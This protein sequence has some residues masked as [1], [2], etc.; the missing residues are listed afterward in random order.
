VLQIVNQLNTVTGV[1]SLASVTAGGQAGLTGLGEPRLSG[2]G[3]SS[4]IVR[5]G[6]RLVNTLIPRLQ[7]TAAE[8]TAVATNGAGASVVVFSG[9]GLGDD[10]GV[11]ARRYDERGLPQ[12]DARLVNTTIRGNQDSPAVAMA[13]DGSSFIVWQGRGPGDRHGIFGQRLGAVGTP[14]G[15]ETRINTTVGGSQ[16][17]A[18]VALAADGRGVVV[19][20]GVGSGDLDGVFLQR[21]AVDGSPVGAEMR[22]NTTVTDQQ[23]YPSVAMT[24]AGA[25]V[26]T[27]S[28]RH[29]DGSD[30]G[31]YGQ[32]FN[33][34]GVP[35]GDEFAV[36]S[37][38]LASQ[39]DSSVAINGAGE[40]VVVWSGYAL[41]ATGWN[42]Y[43]RC[44]N[45]D[46]QPY[47]REMMMHSRAGGQQKAPSVAM[48]A[49]G[50]FLVTWTDSEPNGAGREVLARLYRPTREA[51]T[52]AFQVNSIIVGANSGHQQYS[53]V[54]VGSGP[55]AWIAW[56]GRG[57]S[58]DQGVFADVWETGRVN[59]PPVLNTIPAQ[60]VDEETQLTFTAV[61]SD[62]DL[63]PNTLQYSLDTGFPA[64]A[65]IDP[66]SG[67][68]TWTP[69]EAQ[70]P[71]QYAVVVRV[72]DNG[73]PALS[74]T[75]TVSI[76]VREVN[77]PPALSAIPAQAVDEES[78][79]TFTAVASDP[80]LP[81]NTLQ[82]SL[83]AGAPVGGAIDPAS[84]VFS[85][86]PT[87]AQGP[88]QYSVVVR[89]TD[90]GQP[91]L[92]DTETVAITVRE[93]NQPPVLN[94]IP[95]QA[96]DEQTQLTFTAV[97]SDPDLPGNTL[98]F[99][100]DAGAPASAAIDPA[101]GVFTW[102]PTE[103]QGPGQYSVVVRVTDNGQLALGDTETVSITVREVNRPPVLNAI[104]AQ[105]VDEE[106]Q[107]TFT[108]VAS[109]P[110]L[111]ANTLQFS[112]DAGAPASA[113]IDP[114]SGV[115]S[116]RP[117]EAQGPGQY[118]VVVRVTD[119][120]QPALSD[121]ETVSITVREVNRPPVLNT[122]PPQGVDEQTQLTFTAVASDADLP[123]NTLQFSLDAGAPASAA[124]DSASGVFT[125]TPTEAQGP[126]QYSVVVR[127]T[128]NG[129]PALSDTET[130]SITVREVNQL[131]TLQPISDQTTE[132]G[133]QVTLV[134]SA[135]DPDLP[136]NGL[137]FRLGTGAPER[138]L[139]DPVSGRFTWTPT[140]A[141]AGQTYAVTVA[142]DDDGTPPLS[143]STTFS[144]QVLATCA[145]ANDLNGWTTDIAPGSAQR[146]GTVTAHAC[147]A[148]MTEGDSL[149]VVLEKS[150][151]IPT[152]PS[153][154]RVAFDNLSFDT[155]DPDSMN[156]AFEMALVDQDGNSL[157]RTFAGGRD[158]FLNISEGWPA[159]YR[160]GI[161]VDGNTVTVGLNG[162]PAGLPAKI[163][164]R[165]VNNDSDYATTVRITDFAIVPSNLSAASPGGTLAG[166]A[167]PDVESVS[168]VQSAALGVVASAAPPATLF[169]PQGVTSSG[170]ETKPAAN[171]FLSDGADASPE[172]IAD[173][174]PLANQTGAPDSRGTDFWLAFPENASDFGDLTLRLFVTGEM[175]TTGTVTIPG[176]GFSSSFSVTAG[177]A[178][179]VEVPVTAE[180]RGS[181]TVENKGI[182]VTAEHEVTV[183]GLSRSP[184]E[185]DAY[186]G[187]PTDVLGTEYIALGYQNVSTVQGTQ[188]AVVGTVDGTTVTIT[189]TVSGNLPQS[190]VNVEFRDPAGSV[191]FAIN[192]GIDQGPRYL[193]KSGTYMLTVQGSDVSRSGTYVFRLLDLQ[194][195]ATPLAL[196]S[197]VTDTLPTGGEAAVY[198]FRGTFGQRLYYDAR[199]ADFDAVDLRLI[200]PSGNAVFFGNSDSDF[201]PVGLTED[202]VY[203]LLVQ[204]DTLCRT[205]YRFRLSDLSSA[206]ALSLNTEMTGTLP[207][208]R[209]VAAYQFSGTAGQRLYYDGLDA[210]FDGVD[211]RLIGPRE[212]E[213]F[214]GNSDSDFGP[215]QLTEDGTY[216]LLVEG[217]T[218]AGA[219]YRFR[220][221]D[222]S[223][224][225]ALALDTVKSGAL[226]TGREAAMY[227][228]RGTFGQRLYYD[229]LDADF[230]AVD[231][232]LIGPSGNETFRGNS[233][234]DAGLPRLLEDGTYYLLVQGDTSAVTDY[235]FR[236]SDLSSAP[237]LALNTEESGA[238]PTGREAAVYQ[239]R[240]TAGQQVYYDALDA[241]FDAVDVRLIGPRDN[242]VFSQN[243]DFDFGPFQ[244]TEDGTYYLL[245]PGNTSGVV[246]YRFRLSNLSAAPAL[247]LNTLATGALPTGREAAVYQFTGTFGQRLY[248]D[249]LDADFDAV[250]VRLIAPRDNPVFSQNSDS[251][252]GPFQLTEDG[253]YYLLVPGNTSGVVDYRFQLSDVSSA[254]AL[255]L[256]TVVTGALPTGREA[257]VY[258]FSGTAGQRL[259]YDSLDAECDAV[260]IRL[261]GPRGDVSDPWKSDS[262]AGPRTLTEDGMYYLLVPGNTSGVVD[263]RFQLSDLSSAPVLA[264]NTEES[265][266][267]PTGRE[268]AVYQFRG[269]A[270]QRLYYDAL[271]ADFD[272]VDVRLIG[273]RD[274]RV[275]SQNS[276]SD[277]GPFQL[278]EDGTY[279]LVVPG[280]TS[281][282]VDY[283]FRL[284]DVSSAPALPLNTVEN[285]TLTSGLQAKAYR[286][287]GAAFQRLSFTSLA[288][289]PASSGNWTLYGSDNQ[290]V[291]WST[292]GS[293]FDATLRTPG[294]YVLVLGG[295]SQGTPID[296]SFQVADT[297]DPS[298]PLSGFGTEQ[299][300]AIGPGEQ[301]RYT[302]SA[303]AGRLV[304]LDST[305]TDSDWL[306][307]RVQDPSNE[308]I[309]R[310]TGALDHGPLYLPKS[311]PYTLT[312]QGSDPSRS[313]TYVFRL[314]DFQTDASPL[315]FGS[316]V[317][318]ALPTG[319]EVAVYQ[320]SGTAG[321]RPY[322]DALDADFD[323]V[324]VRLIGPRGDAWDP[325]N[326]DSDAG[327]P[328]LLED[329]TYYLLVQGD[330][331]AVADYSFCVSDLSSAPALALSTE[332][333]GALPTGR[334]AAMYQFRGTFGQRLY[335]DALDAD[336]DAV[337]VR[338]I[339]P[340][341]NPVFSQNS[342][343]DAGP[344]R[345]T[346]DGTYCLLVQG[347][348]SAGADYRFRL[349]DLSSAPALALNTEESGALPTGREA[350]VYQFR[351]TAGQQLYYDGLDAD[352]DAVDVRLI[353][354]RGNETFRG[355]SDSDAG[356]PRLL[357]DGTYYLLVQ[358]DT[359][360][361]ADYS[362]R[363]N[364]LSS[365]PA[366][367]LNTEES[368]A[369]PTGRE[370][371]VYQ[372]RGTFGQRL[373]YDALDADF[374]AV[375]VRLIDPSGNETFRGN[376]DSDA[377]LPRLLE[378]GTHYLLV[379]GDNSAGADYRFRLSDLSSAP[380]L[381]LNTVVTGT[382]TS[383]LQANAYRFESTVF[384][385]LSFT[386][387][388]ISPTSAGNWTLYGSN[389]Q[390]VDGRTLGSS[391]DA[392][393]D[394]PGTYVLVLAGAS[395]GTPID[396][397]FR[398]TNT[399]DPSIPPS[400]FGTEQ[401]A[402]IRP[403][404]RATYTFSAPAGRL[405]FL[406]T[407]GSRFW[408]GPFQ[409]RLDQGETF[410]LRNTGP[411]PSDLSGSL[412]VA[413][414][415]IAVFGG[416]ECA[417]IP[418]QPLRGS[419]D[420]I[421]E[422][423]PP[424]VTWG[425]QFVTMPL[426]T[427]HGGDT[428]RFLGSQDATRVSV[429][430]V[431]VATLN[432]G[433]WYEQLI[434]G[435][436]LI[437]SDNPI[438]VAQY[439]NGNEFDGVT[440]SDP[441]MMLIPPYEQ[442]LTDYT[443]TVPAVGLS[444][445]YINL[446]ASHA[447]V[448]TI[449]LDGEVVPWDSFAS[450]ATSGFAG[451]QI[452]VHPGRHRLTGALPF[453]VFVYG[454]ADRESYGYPGGLSLARIG[455]TEA[456]TL[457]PDS[458][459][460]AVGGRVTLAATVVDQNGAPIVGARVD[461]TVTGASSKVGC[462][463]TDSSGTAFFTYSRTAQ[464]DDSVTAAV[465]SFRDTS[466][467]HW[468]PPA[469]SYVQILSPQEGANIPAGTSVLVTGQTSSDSLLGR[470]VTVTVDG[471][472]VEALDSG[473]RFFTRLRIGPGENA[474]EFTA[475]DGSRQTPSTTLTL[476][477]M[478]PVADKPE[479]A[480]LSDVSGSIA[481][482][483][484]RTSFNADLKVLYADLALENTGAYTVDG[485][486]LV[487][488]TNLSD[489]TVRV[490]GYDGFTRE[491]IPYFDFSTQVNG[492][493]LGPDEVTSS[494]TLAFYNP[495][496]VQFTYDLIFLGRLNEAPSIT[497]VPKIEAIAGRPYSYDADA[498]DPNG[499]PLAWSLAAGPEGAAIDQAAGLVTWNPGPGDLGT[500]AV[501]LWVGDGRGG[502]SEQRYVLSV[503]APPPNRPPVLT[504]TPVTEARIGVLY[505]YQVD[506]ADPDNDVLSWSLV[507]RP[508]GMQIDSA[509]G[510][511]NW[512][513]ATEQLG[514]QS[515]T[516]Q[517]DDG[518]G[519]I[520][521][522]SY[523]IR[524]YP[525]QT[526][527]APMIISEP[528]IS[529]VAG[530]SYGYT[531]EAL[532]PDKDPL[533]Y[534]LVAGPADMSIDPTS[535]EVSWDLN[536]GNVGEHPVTVRASDGRGA[537]DLQS[538]NLNVTAPGTGEIHGW[539][540]N[541]LDGNGSSI[542]PGTDSSASLAF[543][544]T[545]NPNGNWVSGWVERDS[546]GKGFKPYSQAWQVPLGLD[547][548][549]AFLASDGNPSIQHNGTSQT[550][551]E[552]YGAIWRPGQLS[553]HPGPNGEYSIDRF[554]VPVD[555]RYSITATFSPLHAEHGGTDVH[556]LV[557]GNR[558]YDGE[559]IASAVSF[560]STPLVLVSGDTI[561]IAVGFGSDGSFVHDVTGVD[562]TVSTP[563]P[564]LAGWT[565]YLDQNQN[566]RRD[567]GERYTV[568][569]PDGRYAFTGLPAG[570]YYVAE[571]R[572]PGWIQTAPAMGRYTVA[573]AHNGLVRN[574]DFGNVQQTGENHSPV[575]TSE[576][577]STADVDQLLRHTAVAVDPD[578]DPLTYNLLVAPRGM[579]VHPQ[580]GTLVWQPTED[581]V[582]P[583]DVV[584]R[585]T[586]GR[587]GVALQSFQIM[588]GPRNSPPL[589]TSKPPTS[590]FVGLPYEYDVRALDPDND[591]IAFHL[592]TAPAGMNIDGTTGVIRWENP[593]QLSELQFVT[594]D[595]WRVTD[596][597][598]GL[599]WTTDLD[600]DDSA[601]NG[602][603]AAAILPEF[604]QGWATSIWYNADPGGYPSVAWFRK[605]IVLA[606]VPEVARLAG[607]FDDDGEL[608]VNGV[609]VFRDSDGVVSGFDLDI[610][611]FLTPGVNVIAARVQD[612]LGGNRWFA[613]VGTVVPSD[614]LVSV[615]A[616][617]GRGGQDTQTYTLHVAAYPPGNN[618]PV[619]VSSAPTSIQLGH[620]YR[621]QI[622][623][624]DP[625]NDPLTYRIVTSPSFA[626]VDA[627][628]MLTWSPAWY[629][630]GSRRFVVGA[631]DGR[632]NLVTQEF[633]I[634]VTT[635][636]SNRA[637]VIVSTPGH[638]AIVA[639]Q[640]QYDALALD[641]DNDPLLW[642]LETAP[643]GMSIDPMT[644]SI[645]WTPRSGQLGVH[646]VRVVVSDGQGGFVK[647][648][649]GVSDG[650][651]GFVKQFFQI[652]VSSVDRPPVVLSV[653]PT[654]AFL[655]Q[656]YVYQVRA[657]DP[658]GDLLSYTL[659]SA[660]DGMTMEPQS[661]LIQWTPTAAQI[662]ERDVTLQISDG[663]GGTTTQ[664][665]T[666]VV[667]DRVPNHPPVITSFPLFTATVAVP[668]S[669]QVTAADPD[670]DPLTFQLPAAA[671]GMTIDG[672]SGLV[673]WTPASAQEG[674]HTVTVAAVD[675]QGAAATQTFS[676]RAGSN[677]PPTINSTPVT[678][679]LAG[680]A[681]RYDVR[682]T[683]VDGDPLTFVLQTGA[684][685]MQVHSQ[686]G[687][688]T[689][690]PGVADIGTYPIEVTVT[691]GRSPTVV[692][693]YQLT[694]TAD[695]EAPQLDLWLS[696]NPIDMAGAVTI[697]VAAVDNVRVATL[698][699]T[700]GGTP[701][702]LD[703]NGRATVPVNTAGVFPVIATAS[704]P[705]GNTAQVS[706]DLTVIDP[707]V[708][709]DP[710]VAITS[711]TVTED[712]ATSRISGPVDV[713]GTAN[714]PDLAFWTLEVAPFEGGDFVEFARGTRPVSGGVLGRFDPSQLPNGD[715]FLRLYAMDS[716]GNDAEFQVLISVV[717]DLKLGNF[718]LSFTD[719]SI[720]VAG[721]P[722]VAT[723]T[724]DTLNAGSSGDFGYGWRLDIRDTDLR[725]SVAK[726]GRE[727][728]LVYNPIYYNARV[729]VTVPGGRRE[730]F[731]FQPE[732][733]RLYKL[734]Y[735]LGLGS[736]MTPTYVPRFIPDEGVTS[737]LKVQEVLLTANADGEFFDYGSGLSYNP[738]SPLE[739]GA[740]TL[741]TKEGVQYEIDG[742]TGDARKVTDPNGNALTFSDEGIF[743]TSG[744]AI[745]FERD[746][747][748]RITAL[749]DPNGN[750]VQY[751]YDAR[752]DLV[753]VTDREGNVTRFV[754]RADPA[755]Y[756]EQVVDPLG[757]TGVRSVYDDQGRLVRMVDASGKTVELI[758][759]PDHFTETVKD[760]LGNPTVY[761]YDNRG[762][763]VT[764]IDPEGGKTT[765]T[766]DE[767]NNM[768]TETI[769]LSGGTEL[770]ATRTYD[771]HGNVVTET[772]PLG[773]VTRYTYDSFGHVLTTTDPLGNTVTN[774][775]DG[776]GNLLS[777]TDPAGGVTGFSYDAAG[778]MTSMTD[779]SGGSTSFTY[780]GSGNVTRQ[781]DAL[782]NATTYTY[783]ANGNRITETRT[784]TTPAGP[785]TLVTT[786]AY[787]DNG[788]AVAVTDAEGHTTRTEYDA[789]GNRTATID[790]LGRRTEFRYDE[791]GQLV[792]TIYPDDTPADLTDNPRT[793]S[794]Y[795][796]AGG[797]TAK[798]DE[799]GRRTEMKYD[800]VGRLV[801][802][803]YPDGT[804]DDSTVVLAER[805]AENGVERSGANTS[806]VLAA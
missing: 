376:S 718:T 457:S 439:S 75:E 135:S 341:G 69:T 653:P 107:L 85:W 268:A 582:G 31:I 722:I 600:F 467:V 187:L 20:D 25:F 524:V 46:G 150:F 366:L 662:G 464:G 596:R 251:D 481:G 779:A 347:N 267:L 515:V 460:A 693:T 36:N 721:I 548:W 777:S 565:I 392:T 394:I 746:Y 48:F 108:A 451:A 637:P 353:A 639:E 760:Q 649:V 197:S 43:G 699:L 709:G 620:L 97:A 49:D 652:G 37:G 41:D 88:G 191:L 286:F 256:N 767:H 542:I 73:Q 79:L 185:T 470:V 607:A 381:P 651:G 647:Q 161:Q 724:Y 429:N 608:Y 74:D 670:G 234:S 593:G 513:P 618:P 122:I 768:L 487:G 472:P 295:A 508:P 297:S 546:L 511:I 631:D 601:A 743:S 468:R 495:S 786:T 534:S 479:F 630:V 410:Q 645:Y 300:V 690:S 322:Y 748:G 337:D 314:L 211:V 343:S 71:G 363:V 555:G 697:V 492:S 274:N 129:Q 13:Q 238:L 398:V 664:S 103:A 489:P 142:V 728:D 214:R 463:F 571:E 438:L 12:G 304:F 736:V 265:G 324:A 512:T 208:G 598:P 241:D 349:S 319:R 257:A 717:G 5:Q 538:F 248:Y 346:E 221:S 529:A 625:E 87:E 318:G 732:Y 503:I 741:T 225:P 644:G 89:V 62:P 622:V 769:V 493:T 634:D 409:V 329:G 99:S 264:L 617:D 250:D 754:Y 154:V 40:F 422:E 204:G 345:L 259:Y 372:F 415:P 445:T 561:D 762:N 603:R 364:D 160:E 688:I 157:V 488:I 273:P 428:F 403:G 525:D 611:F 759:D 793:S 292:L 358:G 458:V 745:R 170:S 527:H 65:A 725:T 506:A 141:Q 331:S 789:A 307:V 145:F 766:Y 310:T 247:P 118:S 11:F 564:G 423:L 575:F 38:T 180:L 661:G 519:G 498:T 521:R 328:R 514:V 494:Q 677:S 417:D 92:S 277:F 306:L 362:F 15:S 294:T 567:T 344:L 34:D 1:A 139:V 594:D 720:P 252:F 803:I 101:S 16:Q 378:D 796:A 315:V 317:T 143:A 119:N 666:V 374:D 405:V 785:R 183:Y 764:E 91:A 572:K 660:P 684:A 184:Y 173:A 591:P 752:G 549:G 707:S 336:F 453:G 57:Q 679:V 14:C 655:A 756:L 447:A 427:R 473:G 757:R 612:T 658:D 696:E 636:S 222:L 446:V 553:V 205:D 632:G 246:D 505:F 96:V 117:T 30:W 81:A 701:V 675:P 340:R 86:T 8:T 164:F 430:S 624:V 761:E 776:R 483:Y 408:D 335:Y 397:S 710:E 727:E 249:A 416:H 533:T 590:A 778:N 113:A 441:F 573:L 278:T 84:G 469:L 285:G 224:A 592:D 18:A 276:D 396:Y 215:F 804:P 490:R 35:V 133:I 486:L 650:R 532:D 681:Y 585:A 269:T 137:A 700:V 540:F 321:Q 558:L 599:G 365:A 124:I 151:T 370:A 641:P 520:A 781:V 28:S 716:G 263:Y 243:S 496:R 788:R 66:A 477:G 704:D 291:A 440:S 476:V 449:R 179:T 371:A 47:G 389:N 174:S 382:L 616:E 284:S 136:P 351:G 311:G 354:P 466:V 432:R 683:D 595:S 237:A 309:F 434:D 262:D 509:T 152:T 456:V 412:I 462:D 223:S 217:R 735:M 121:T 206:P 7:T 27:W 387:L 805:S 604:G 614:T 629:H 452:L 70:G 528:L 623:A 373:Y 53:A 801:E 454:F 691:D 313:G 579:T 744:K 669:Y 578:D 485:P 293:S 299:S 544:P 471:V 296:Y 272:A 213:T 570:T 130:V 399:S 613:L 357:E 182:H 547:L 659:V 201:G 153:A 59:R 230:D 581:Q 333:S 750:R 9:R 685:G 128:D 19:W 24:P 175:D 181:S 198:Q 165:L 577:P 110:D 680:A 332:E 574:A 94:T 772:D 90:N 771:S 526:N 742:E 504:S 569:D 375:D 770:T 356:L 758:H 497:T 196:G 751:S 342:D 52:E 780:D 167:Q 289:S 450:I 302:F 279:Y 755:H 367:A 168:H 749:I 359:S 633:A 149:L 138:S 784:V 355:N 17:H 226:P 112:L 500:Q 298:V 50:G 144:V 795:D 648:C 177:T 673:E 116:W 102:T 244:L 773:N 437:T 83:D 414:K 190:R 587:G 163:I 156:D 465:G 199:D 426:A 775:Y 360:A 706:E 726:T 105:A 765:R 782:G 95:A 29:Q 731:T 541:D 339:G 737:E 566:G 602:W 189:P 419:C 431:P 326:S 802:T 646:D 393:L 240:G 98:Q 475:S 288:I 82:F 501:A 146:R 537:F 444:I 80:D 407:V 539:T 202:G 606:G 576:P 411:A 708:A 21:F 686:L 280:N 195:D 783:D 406:D 255:A 239:F 131:P 327:L 610:R 510:L 212:N 207:T 522:Q 584:L 287:E 530:T 791:R 106:S 640:Y 126:G 233:D 200:G 543:S 719:L 484:G 111:P 338:L 316:S 115:F 55:R 63:P 790:A 391:F 695:T 158:G 134:A 368:G 235:S 312:V 44:F 402:T 325:W 125:W 379:Q 178:T 531:V 169:V 254:P 334:E 559:V 171:G 729:Y 162:L 236:V 747:A 799:L 502:C 682:A 774:A 507:N 72:T 4:S 642:Y 330:T 3:T 499:D 583:Q 271:D 702:V 140:E 147:T 800:T 104:P 552:G 109:D 22:V 377:V 665:Y 192:D 798:I 281:G 120:G 448:G 93:A 676:L 210:D 734:W 723:R 400:R 352:F 413:D 563:E 562:V 674:V 794:E 420:Y 535:G 6:E 54:A 77:R 33:A 459:A 172:G 738:E 705:A 266:T 68:F 554:I 186:L 560:V 45:A 270:G 2:N 123:A 258:Q 711:P 753:S 619:I 395:P 155:T 551:V 114:A 730:G 678:S 654:N 305:S 461:F 806:S 588:V 763:I 455:D 418:A 713:I 361:V 39:E 626:S 421:V 229:A 159:T 176:I 228:F 26:V 628:G 323:A 672:M 350:A 689:W 792:E 480:N 635:E 203:Y 580:W 712:P 656:S 797:E 663:R 127:V 64:S 76:T 209:E 51:D 516:V 733:S 443:V 348:N 609:Q 261:I 56:C 568:T 232:R 166:Q 424:T 550:I 100:L 193:P 627:F 433:E 218:T 245:V 369:L 42:V 694:V 615:V 739:G 482:R 148:V 404:E 242:P 435:P 60:T 283:R 380:A 425:K 714:D 621:Y 536:A 388:A 687:R 589:I 383:G 703:V 219:D 23:A 61:A 643:S 390:V 787:D 320:F 557:N 303:P 474:F 216:Y 518:H 386:S 478:Q 523:V 668:Y 260:D 586:D 491:G 385:R 227:Q 692:Q 436:A 384:Q 132:A 301:A 10:E 282:V 67:V 188:F 638:S 671:S 667:L 58:D 253:M 220:L 275:F 290:V 401:T 442:F 740:F 715:Y 517:V 32:R 597:Q 194:T 545:T 605:E 231:V 556:V 78:Q 698:G 308:E 657:D